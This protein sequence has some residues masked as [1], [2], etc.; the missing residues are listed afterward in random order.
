[1]SVEQIKEIVA[2]VVAHR[3]SGAVENGTGFLVSQ[4]LAITCAHCLGD[5][6]DYAQSTL[7]RFTSWKRYDN[8]RKGEVIEIDWD[9]DV[10]LLRL[11][12]M[13]QVKLLPLERQSLAEEQWRSFAY[14]Q[15]VDRDG[16][17]LEGRVRDIEGKFHNEEML[18]LECKEIKTPEDLL[19]GASGAPIVVARG[20]IIGILTNQLLQYPKQTLRQGEAI[21]AAF[22]RVYALPLKRLAAHPQF[23]NYLHINVSFGGTYKETYGETKVAYE[24]YFP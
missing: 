1:M 2:R 17:T 24:F 20:A 23:K 18:E 5:P 7:L 13:A 11:D 6:E 3:P 8:D 4:N 9:L 16:I 22:G 14:P 21:I 10:A 19:H 15:Q 12:Q